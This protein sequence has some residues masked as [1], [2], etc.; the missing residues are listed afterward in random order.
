LPKRA[1]LKFGCV[2]KRAKHS[3]RKGSLLTVSEKSSG[4]PGLKK[5]NTLDTGGTGGMGRTGLRHGINGKVL[6]EVA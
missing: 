6:A 4:G 3:G 5:K 1:R 2:P